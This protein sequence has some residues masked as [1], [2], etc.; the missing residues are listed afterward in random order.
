[1]N[2]RMKQSGSNIMTAVHMEWAAWRGRKFSITEA[3]QN[4]SG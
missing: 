2:E 4:K 1:M 3:V